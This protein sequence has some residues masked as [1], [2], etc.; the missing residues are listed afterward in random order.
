MKSKA[1]FSKIFVFI[2]FLSSSLD[3]KT[4]L[5]SLGDALQFAIPAFAF[6]TTL[7]KKDTEGMKEWALS[8]GTSA[9]LTLGIKQAT[10]H[11]SIGRRPNGGKGSFPS[12]HTSSAFQGA[13]FLQ[14]RYGW[15]YGVPALGLACLTA[16][17]RVKGKYHHWRDIGVGAA[18]GFLVNLI[19]TKPYAKN[20]I[21]VSA[22]DEGV[23]LTIS[24]SF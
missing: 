1:T 16:Y 18:M 13:F 10:K 4:A 2:T 20:G 3:A 12:G 23:G 5:T 14:R 15:S 17:S 21:T 11:S 24:K 6:G 7:V 22:A 19:F 8:C 9:L